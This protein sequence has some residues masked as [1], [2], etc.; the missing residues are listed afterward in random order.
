M[1]IATHLSV[2]EVEQAHSQLFL[3]FFPHFLLSQLIEKFMSKGFSSIETLFWC[4]NH[5]LSYEVYQQGI[6]IREDLYNE[7]S[8]MLPVS[9]L[10]FGEFVVV[11]VIL[12]IHLN[13][14]SFCGSSHHFDDLDKVVDAALSDK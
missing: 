12:W 9:F 10:N 6:G 14:L 5:N 2:A 11:E 13:D 1:L 8:Y 4:V 3:K 7:I